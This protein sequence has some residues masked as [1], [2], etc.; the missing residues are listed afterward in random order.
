MARVLIVNDSFAASQTLLIA[1]AGGRNL[2][3]EAVPFASVAS[4]WSASLAVGSR[5][6]A[7][8]PK[9]QLGRSLYFESDPLGTSLGGSVWMNVADT[10]FTVSALTSS[11]GTSWALRLRGADSPMGPGS[12][13]YVTP[14]AG[15]AGGRV[16][17]ESVALG[18]M[19]VVDDG[20]V[21]FN[22]GVTAASP[23]VVG[24]R[25]GN[26]ALASLLTTLAS[27]GLI[28]DNTTP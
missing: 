25:G 19:V 1:G 9:I 6:G 23:A 27:M 18:T 7:N 16:V 21:A 12:D 17:L 2:P 20:G 24:S 15:A 3:V 22:G 13:V 26:A 5:S 4:A 28:T 14:G 8:N 10:E 11:D